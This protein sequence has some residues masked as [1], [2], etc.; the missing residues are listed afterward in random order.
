MGLEFA[1][2]LRDPVLRGRGVLHGDGQPVLLL[3]GLLAGDDSLRI[4]ARWLKATGHRPAR[5]GI[6]VNV[7]CSGAAIERLEDRLEALVRERGMRAAVIG[8]SRGGSFAKV[9]A[10]RRPD[11]VSG[12][13]TLGCPHLDTFAVHP[14][15]R[16]QIETLATLGKLGL[17]GL[18]T[19]SCLEGEC[20]EA[21]WEA[22]RS[23]LKRGVGYVS[24]Y[25][26][27]DGI[28]NWE[29]CLDPH[30]EHI[31]VSSTH[32]GM[33]FH[34]DVFRTVAESLERFRR[35]DARRRPLAAEGATVTPIRRA[36]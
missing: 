21:F 25:S 35:S 13:V 4:M 31:E 36:A 23:P 5:A 26:R 28:V 33:A 27:T 6:L 16:A 32:C 1:A 8:H 12:V 14:L 22:T 17:P 30:G 20:C 9:L 15:V 24:I 10:H 3:P 19:R 29:S 7:D 18:F 2:L 11:L 34:P